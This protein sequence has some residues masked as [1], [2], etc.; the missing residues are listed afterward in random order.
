MRMRPIIILGLIAG[1]LFFAFYED[2]LGKEVLKGFRETPGLF[3]N[4]EE[5]PLSKEEEAATSKEPEVKARS[6]KDYV[7]GTRDILHISVWENADLSMEVIVRPDGK[8][9]F[10]LIDEVQAQ[11]LTIPEL[12]KKITKKLKE[13]L[14]FP[15][16][17]ISLRRIGGSKVIIL[18][19]VNSPGV[20]ILTGRRNVLEAIASA[21]GFTESAVLSS[22]IVIKGSLSS[23]E[24]ERVNLNKAISKADATENITLDSED[25][26]F[27]P[28]RFIANL[29]YFLSRVLDPISR[30][31]YTSRELRRW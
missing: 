19:Q 2:G 1:H 21:G 25:I 30:G 11:G 12:D 4:K 14:H 7:I 3:K 22:V 28:K 20:Y 17:S 8:V 15:D 26:I 31:I 5:I 16:V 6:Q 18:G 27:V 23:A 10:P 9:S 13:Y 24:A 29:N